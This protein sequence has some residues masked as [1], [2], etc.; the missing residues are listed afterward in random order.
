M[1]IFIFETTQNI[2]NWTL[3]M[4]ENGLPIHKIPFPAIT[5]CSETKTQKAMVNVTEAY[6]NLHYNF[7]DNSYNEEE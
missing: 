7:D 2:E 6:H 3:E 1:S 5:I 4:V